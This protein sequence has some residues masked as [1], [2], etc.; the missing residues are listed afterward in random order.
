MTTRTLLQGI[1]VLALGLGA[2]AGPSQAAASLGAEI[3][4]PVVIGNQLFAGGAVLLRPVGTGILVQV[5]IAGRP[6]AS[7]FRD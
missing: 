6:V 3:A 7:V 4:G 5:L 2:A 1:A